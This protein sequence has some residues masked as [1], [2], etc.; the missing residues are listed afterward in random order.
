M[1]TL[2]DDQEVE[3]TFLAATAN[4][5]LLGPLDLQCSQQRGNVLEQL[6]EEHLTCYSLDG[7][8]NTPQR[9]LI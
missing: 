7:F 8:L 4:H 6:P 9:Y 5:P 2:P 1:Q 3:Q